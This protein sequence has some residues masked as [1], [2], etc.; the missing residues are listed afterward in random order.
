MGGFKTGF[1]NFKRMLQIGILGLGEG[2]STMSAALQSDRYQLKMICDANEELCKQRSDEFNFP[3][4]TTNYQQMLNDKD[5]DV[6]AIYTPDHLHAQHVKQ[7]LFH[8]K[9][10]VCTK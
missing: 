5:I 10:V 3:N 2:R 9:N 4:Y 1:L 8:N 6:I 7:A